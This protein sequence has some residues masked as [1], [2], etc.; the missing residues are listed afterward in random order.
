MLAVGRLFSVWHALQWYAFGQV[1]LAGAAVFTGV[2]AGIAYRR[3]KRSEAARWLHEFF[4]TFH[5]RADILSARDVLNYDYQESLGP[6]LELRVTDRH[7]ALS[8]SERELLRQVDLVLNYFEEI[9]YLVD[10]RHLRPQDRDL[11]FSYWLGL[12]RIPERAGLRRYIA[13]C[14]YER[15]ASWCDAGR[16]TEYVVLPELGSGSI[17]PSSIGIRYLDDC[18]LRAEDSV[19]V[20][21]LAFSP[22]PEDCSGRIYQVEKATAFLELD[23]LIGYDAGMRAD[24]EIVRRCVRVKEPGWDCWV[25]VPAGADVDSLGEGPELHWTG[26]ADWRP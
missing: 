2:S 19:L 12:V 17:D 14:G 22:G 18:R 16:L 13:R 20:H 24:C 9:L 3:A 25:Y 15:L 23:R 11:F 21:P 7:V 10:E 6:V 4:L 26:H 1:V 5:T 8:Q